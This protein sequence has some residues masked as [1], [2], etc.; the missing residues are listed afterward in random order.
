MGVIRWSFATLCLP[1]YIIYTMCPG[2]RRSLTHFTHLWLN[3]E[4]GLVL[5]SKLWVVRVMVILRLGLT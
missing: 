1:Y 2:S 5:L 4:L 3:K